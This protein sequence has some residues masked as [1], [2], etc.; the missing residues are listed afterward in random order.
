MNRPAACPGSLLTLVLAA[1]A[2]G[3]HA[4][5]DL[6]VDGVS[7]EQ[8]AEVVRFAPIVGHGLGRRP[9]GVTEYDLEALFDQHVFRR[10]NAVRQVRLVNGRMVIAG[11]ATRPAGET[12]E[13]LAFLR[14]V[15]ERRIETLD[16]IC[17]LTESQRE[18]LRL[19]AESDLK[20]LAGEIDLVRRKHVG[21]RVPATPRGVDRERL[22]A[23]RDDAAACRRRIEQ[24]F[25][26]GSLLCSVSFGMLAPPQRS[27][28]E[29]WLADRRRTG[30]EAMAR[31]VLAQI[32]ESSLGFSAAQ[33]DQLLGQLLAD[34]PPLEV[35][36]DRLETVASSQTTDFQY[37]LVL[38]RL[39]RLDQAALRSIC[40]P[41]Q[42]SAL[43][44]RMGQQGDPEA[45]EQLLV[46]QGVLEEGE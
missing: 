6:V 16:G 26:P 11:Q 28:L 19:A 10:L 40:D 31:T 8:P 7:V 18:V 39:K 32:D 37:L 1:A 14:P 41:R 25:R 4:G 3:L 45:M 24:I 33:H 44:Q 22:Q 42:W 13:R 36:G 5:D 12:L 17:R 27:A 2:V 30:W 9:G 29:A 23:V 20:R 35:F 15:A 21:Q 46:A 43:E 38:S 34:V